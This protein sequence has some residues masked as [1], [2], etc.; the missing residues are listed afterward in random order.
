[1]FDEVC[2]THH[3]EQKGKNNSRNTANLTTVN[4]VCLALA[5]GNDEP[6]I[7]IVV[8]ASLTLLVGINFTS[9]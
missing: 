7:G 1:M 6:R 5:L 4:K 8:E 3:V 2:F 9:H